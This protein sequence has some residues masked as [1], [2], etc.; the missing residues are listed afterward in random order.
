MPAVV[1]ELYFLNNNGKKNKE[2]T[3]FLEQ[4]LDIIIRN[5]RLI[6][7]PVVLDQHQI[8]YAEKRGIHHFPAMLI[9]G[10]P[11]FEGNAAL[12]GEIQ[13]R[14]RQS[15]APAVPKTAEERTSDFWM[16]EMGVQ[17]DPRQKKHIIP[18]DDQGDGDL[19][20]ELR[21]RATAEQQRRAEAMASAKRGPDHQAAQRPT[22]PKWGADIED[23]R[24]GPQPM[25]PGAVAQARQGRPDNIMAQRP[26]IGANG[27]PGD[28]KRHLR[29]GDDDE[30]MAKLLDNMSTD[31]F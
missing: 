28:P 13:R 14:M 4:Y 5:A 16:K 19:G 3:D 26:S 21:N 8:G 29:G 25:Q 20:N 27:G 10:M 31:G 11:P 1:A 24:P 17:Y 6:I 2:L 15:R 30:L 22:G 7:K 18:D 23:H 9:T 12:I